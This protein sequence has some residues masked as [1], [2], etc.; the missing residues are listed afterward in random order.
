MLAEFEFSPVQ[1]CLDTFYMAHGPCCA[2]CDWWHAHN[3]VA[4]DCLASAPVP[5]AE[6]IGM[7]GITGSSLTPVAGHVI[8][9]REHHCGDFVDAFDWLLLPAGYLN[10]IGYPPKP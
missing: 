8:T 1:R 7:L 4:G 6:R 2:G 9:P 5:G 10:R 3:S